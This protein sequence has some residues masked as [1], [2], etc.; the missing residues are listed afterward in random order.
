MKKTLLFLGCLALFVAGCN[1]IQTVEEPVQDSPRHLK[2]NIKVNHDAETRS[3]KTGWAAGDKIYVTF[4][5]CFTSELSS[6][7]TLTYN[8]S[9]W[10]SEFSDEA[11]EQLLLEQERGKLAAAYISSDRKPVFQYIPPTEDNPYS[12]NIMMTNSEGLTGMYLSA[13]DVQYFVEDGTLTAELNM[14][15]RTKSLVHFYLGG[16][17]VGQ[18]GNYTLNCNKLRPM[19]FDHFISV[20]LDFPNYY[21]FLGPWTDYKLGELGEPIPASYYDGGI[22]FNC[23]L[24]PTGTGSETEFVFYLVDNNGTPNDTSDDVTYA[25]TKTTT[26]E[27]GEAIRFPMLYNTDE[28]KVLNPSD[29]A[30]EFSGYDDEVNW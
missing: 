1:K 7:L 19:H 11:L 14:G 17:S 26:L 4:D 20:I 3:V 9:S 24:D 28:W 21:S 30:P 23:Y 29:I 8:G 18:E 12:Y 5:V 13:D 25:L 15:L 27:G 10:T 2:V 16:V 6:C 22:E